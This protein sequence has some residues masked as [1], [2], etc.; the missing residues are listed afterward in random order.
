M[1][2]MKQHD[3]APPLRATLTNTD[4]AGT[5]TPV[6]LTAASA[7]KVIGSRNGTALFTRTVTG[8]NQGV[9]VMPWSVG[10]TAAPGL[11]NVEIEVTWPGS[12][13]TVQTFPANGTLTVLVDKD[14]G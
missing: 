7:V 9:V 8:T 2:R 12:P 6:D 5:I 4:D 13:A 10:D 3:T 1:F 14:L 11:I